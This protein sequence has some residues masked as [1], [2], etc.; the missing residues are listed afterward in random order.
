MPSMVS[1]AQSR[2]AVQFCLEKKEASDS[3]GQKRT[4]KWDSQST[5]QDTRWE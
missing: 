3:V 1:A 5:P 4:L 2:R